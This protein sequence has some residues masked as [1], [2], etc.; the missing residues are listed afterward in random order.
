MDTRFGIHFYSP[1]VKQNFLFVDV[2]QTLNK[3]PRM[4]SCGTSA[5]MERIS[6]IESLVSIVR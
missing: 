3:G 6:N 5:F 2:Y 1:F 4:H